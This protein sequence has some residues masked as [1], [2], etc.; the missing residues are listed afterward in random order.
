MEVTAVV[1]MPSTSNATTTSIVNVAILVCLF[2]LRTSIYFNSA[3][4]DQIN[5]AGLVLYQA[6]L[7]ANLQVYTYELTF[8]DVYF[9]DPDTHLGIVNDKG[10]NMDKVPLRYY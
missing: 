5:F 8:G 10:F 4:P 9:K 3:I 6:N 2:V 7:T 1:L